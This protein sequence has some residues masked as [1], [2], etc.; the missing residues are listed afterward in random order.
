M[1]DVQSL[2]TTA[3]GYLGGLPLRLLAGYRPELIARQLG[4]R[5]VSERQVL[6]AGARDLDPPE[7]SHLAQSQIRRAGATD[8]DAAELPRGPLYAHVDLDVI[9]NAALPGLRYRVAAVGIACT[10]HPGRGAAAIA[11]IGPSSGRVRT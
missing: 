9:D 8:L 2:E 1:V 4:L 7:V 11:R 5:P 6:L 10:W 3:S